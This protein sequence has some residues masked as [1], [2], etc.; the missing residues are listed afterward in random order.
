MSNSHGTHPVHDANNNTCLVEHCPLCH[1]AC[2]EFYRSL[3]VTY[4]LCFNITDT[5]PQCAA[6][7]KSSGALRMP[8]KTPSELI[9]DG[10]DHDHAD[11]KDDV[12]HENARISE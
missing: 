8:N 1:R 6:Q 7:S 5:I 2:F 10:D 3:S 12:G 4:E 11:G 9:G